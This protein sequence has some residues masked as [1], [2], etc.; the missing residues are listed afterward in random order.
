MV[1]LWEHESDAK[2]PREVK[3]ENPYEITVLR[4]FFPPS[5]IAEVLIDYRYNAGAS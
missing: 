3:A 1:E 2:L 4:E 5:A